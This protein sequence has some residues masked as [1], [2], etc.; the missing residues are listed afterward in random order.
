MRKITFLLTLLLS[1]FGSVGS[2]RA[3]GLLPST[4]ESASAEYQYKIFCRNASTY[5]LGN[6]TNATNS[7]TDYGL[8]AFF[9]DNSGDYTNGYYIYSIFEG[10]WVSYEAAASYSGG[11]NKISLVVD[12][13]SV[14]WNISE[15]NSDNKYYDI[16]P[17]KTDKT[18]DELSWNWYDGAAKNT[19]NTM[20]FYSYTDGNSGWGIVLAGGSGSTVADR[21]V[22]ALYN[23]PSDNNQYALYNS[24]GTPKVYSAN[25]GV[26][27]QYFVLKQNGLDTNGEALYRLQ[28]AEMDGKSLNYQTFGDGLN[29]MFL[30]TSSYYH[31]KFTITTSNQPEWAVSPYYNLYRVW[32]N[33]SDNS[34]R[35]YSNQVSQCDDAVVNMYSGTSNNIPAQLT[36]KGGWNGRWQVVEQ[37]YTA[38]QV[39]ITGAAGGTITYKGSSL[40]SGATT[41][42]SNNGMFVINSANTPTS[43]DFTINNVDGYLTDPSI[44]FDT[45]RKLI[46]VTYT[47]YATIYNTIKDFL[48]NTPKGI[49]YPTAA[50]RA[51]LQ[52]AIDAFDASSKV[53]SDLVT[54]NTAYTTFQNTT[55]VNL[56]ELGKVYTIQSYVKSSSKTAYLENVSG[57]F[58]ISTDASATMLNNL[59]VV[60]N[61]GKLQSAA[62]MTNYFTYASAGLTAT[63]VEWTFSKGTEWPYLAMWNGDMYASGDGRYLGSDASTHV[64]KFGG[65]TYWST[66]IKQATGW[67]TDFIFIERSDYVLYKVKILYPSG[68]APT[69]TYNDNTFSNG[70]D[71][72]APTTLTTGDLTVSEISGYTPTVTIDGDI[73]YV[74]YNMAVT[75]PYADTWDFDN[76][77]W[78]LLTDVPAT[79]ENAER[80][81]RYNT[82]RINIA[83][84]YNS[85]VEVKFAYSSGSYRIDVAGVDLI[86]PSTGNVVKGDYHDGYSGSYQS[87]REY[88]IRDV[89]PGNY[90]LRYISYDQSTSSA[91]NISVRVVP[92]Q[93]FYRLKN[94]ATGKYLTATAIGAWD[95]STRYV[96]ANGNNTAASTVLRLY[97]KDSNGTLYMYNQGYGFGWTATNHG[98]GVAW[99]TGSP[100]KYVNWFPGTADGR[101]AFAICFGNGTGNYASYLEKGIYTV[102][103]DD[104]AVIAGDDKTADAAQWKIEDATEVAVTLHKAGDAS[105]ATFC[106]PFDVT[107]D[108]ATAYKITR[109]NGDASGCVATMTAIDGTVPAGTPVVL[110]NNDATPATSCTATI[111]TGSAT[112]ASEPSTENNIL[113][114]TFLEKNLE[115]NDLVLGVS[116]GVPGFYR[117]SDYASVPLGANKA[118]ISLGSSEG[119]RAFVFDSSTLTGLNVINQNNMQNDIYD[120]QGRR[121]M[122]AA[123]G[124]YIIN[125]KKVFVK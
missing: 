82:K 80:T 54:L 102:D 61:S 84:T 41:T 121:V 58:T 15:D 49:G 24:S 66:A 92:G 40:L 52:S 2:M 32:P 74:N 79:I 65:G 122:Q 6:T 34:S 85:S 3:D 75:A 53:T 31:S 78:S 17:F 22:V 1:L 118:Y 77:P 27:P 81:Y 108:G 107:F 89:A 115:E 45:N 113:S 57:T 50:T 13:P 90:I 23:V 105:Y 95:S 11:Q 36:A 91:G 100:D 39:I 10:K 120:L 25:T 60:R 123:K 70:S 112:S 104:D 37:S 43:S 114:G 68:S 93:G 88:A 96:Y 20:G 124:L 19:S 119:I 38:W 125:G 30:N 12:K 69:V 71:F 106:A 103:T 33:A 117:T 4:K 83:T 21:K 29:Y 63:G 16:R 56:P 28:K 47:E 9:A 55:N 7:G 109:G 111:G 62:D 73:V 94:V 64:G 76:S 35:P 26:T 18:V 5:Y 87:N 86:D 97:D 101:L 44:S 46:K 116:G 59:W 99:I 42:Q 72:V 51:T 48:D 67:S 14:P 8:F 98:G 110:V